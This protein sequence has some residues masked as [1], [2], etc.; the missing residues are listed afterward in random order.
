MFK[1][2]Q[3][4]TNL[5]LNCRKPAKAGVPSLVLAVLTF[6][7]V[8]CNEVTAS[9]ELQGKWQL[10]QEVTNSSCDDNGTRTVTLTVA[11]DGYEIEVPGTD[12]RSTEEGIPDGSNLTFSISYAEPSG[13]EITERFDVSANGTTMTGSSTYTRKEGGNTTCTGTTRIQGKRMGGTLTSEGLCSDSCEYAGDGVCDDG[14]PDAQYEDCAYGT[15]CGDCG[16][17]GSSNPTSPPTNPTKPTGSC[18]DT[19]EYAGDGV[20]DDGG[21]NALYEDCAYGTDCGDCGPR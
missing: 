6:A 11:A 15:D 1:S 16:R 10:T 8:G 19:C 20:C 21:P 18:S 14:G 3:I 9:P 5:N 12:R 13:A 17:R 7:S 4:A 2:N